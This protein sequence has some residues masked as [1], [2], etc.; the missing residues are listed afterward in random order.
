[1]YF[2]FGHRHLPLEIKLNERSTYINIGEWLNFNS[3]GVFD[4]EKMRLEYFEK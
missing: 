3:Y 2:V 1:D 4:G